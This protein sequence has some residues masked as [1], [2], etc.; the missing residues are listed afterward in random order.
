M[1]MLRGITEPSSLQFGR[2]WQTILGVLTCTPSHSYMRITASRKQ[3]HRYHR[4][5]SSCRNHWVRC[6]W[7]RCH[8]RHLIQGISN[9]N[10]KSGSERRS[11]K[12]RKG[13]TL[14]RRG[15]MTTTIDACASSHEKLI[16]IVFYAS[17][18]GEKSEINIFTSSPQSLKD[19]NKSLMST[20]TPWILKNQNALF[21]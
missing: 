3:Q 18:S 12:L 7:I 11:C 4:S 6:R 19:L 2:I 1:G 15:T 9:E 20:K 8:P 10:R 17:G 13:L 14:Q 16:L 21:K 5:K